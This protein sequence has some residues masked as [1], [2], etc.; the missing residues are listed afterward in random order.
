MFTKKRPSM[1]E[2][3]KLLYGEE[4]AQK[5]ADRDAP[6]VGDTLAVAKAAAEEFCRKTTK[7]I[8]NFQFLN[9]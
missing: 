1:I 4:M 3:F 2:T 6:L 8:T 9:D 5:I 7:K